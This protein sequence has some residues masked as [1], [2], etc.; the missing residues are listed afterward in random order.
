MGATPLSSHIQI[1]LIWHPISE[2]RMD[3]REGLNILSV[4]NSRNNALNELDFLAFPFGDVPNN[5][6][7][8]CTTRSLWDCELAP[9]EIYV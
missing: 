5:Q 1:P 3:K 9:A 2:R 7:S 8:I 6:T 4:G